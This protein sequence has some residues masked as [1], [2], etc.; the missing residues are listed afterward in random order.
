MRQQTRMTDQGA[1]SLDALTEEALAWLVRLHSGEETDQDWHLYHDWKAASAEQRA[2][3]ERAEAMWSRLGPALAG[4]KS[5]KISGALVLMVAL[6]GTAAYSGMLGRSNQWLADEAT[7]IGERRTVHLAD[8]SAVVLDSVTS[9]D[10]EFSNDERRIKL[11]DGQIYVT[12]APNPARPF[13]VEAQ[14]GDVQALGTAFNVR[15][16]EADVSVAVTEHAVRVGMMNAQSV[17]V[18]VGYG[19]D[20]S[21]ADGLGKVAAVDT[22][23]ITAWQRGELVFDNRPLGDVLEDME[24][25]EHGAVIFTDAELKQLPVTGVFSTDD[26]GAFF[27]ALEHAL[28]V[29]V[30]RLPLVTVISRAE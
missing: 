30:T 6:L 20:Y 28:P 9:F 22:A 21:R 11:R 15:I 4:K 13:V 16:D 5:R 1:G 19:V 25:Y 7:G 24:R 3:A 23:S 8:G 14:G 17:D 2:A 18:S 29:R 12:V 26:L 10:V 27:D